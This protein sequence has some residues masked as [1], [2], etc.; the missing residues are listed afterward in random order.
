LPFVVHNQPMC[1]PENE[2]AYRKR[3][4]SYP[5]NNAAIGWVWA[6]ALSELAPDRTV[7][8]MRRGAAYGDHRVLCGVHWDT[9]IVAGRTVGAALYAQLQANDEFRAQAAAARRELQAVRASADRPRPDCTLEN[10]VLG[11]R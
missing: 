10:E 6:M 2:A 4:N 8:L 5:S 1:T 9:D 7:E 3:T 11:R